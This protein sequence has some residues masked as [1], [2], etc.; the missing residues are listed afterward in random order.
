M[1][2]AAVQRAAGTSREDERP[3]QEAFGRVLTNA[4]VLGDAGVSVGRNRR[5][6]GHIAA[7]GKAPAKEHRSAIAGGTKAPVPFWALLCNLLF[8]VINVLRPVYIQL[9]NVEA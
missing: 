9:S 3:P 6:G 1:A 4:R 8:P 2:W 5:N 7:E